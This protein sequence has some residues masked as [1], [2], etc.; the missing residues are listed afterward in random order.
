MKWVSIGL[1]IAP[2]IVTAIEAVE[3]LVKGKGREKQ[4]AAVAA[5]AAALEA[6]EAGAGRDLLDDAEVE[7]AMRAAIDAVVAVQNVIARKRQQAP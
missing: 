1:R 5:I 4:D 7:A 2:L 3:R 6:I